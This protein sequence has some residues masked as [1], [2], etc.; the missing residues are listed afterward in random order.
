PSKKAPAK[1]EAVAGPE[2]KALPKT[3][4]EASLILPSLGLLLASAGYVFKQPKK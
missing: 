4:A 1:K 2:K 3:G